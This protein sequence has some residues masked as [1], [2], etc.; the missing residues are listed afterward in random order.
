MDNADMEN[1]DM[2]NAD[3]ENADMENANMENADIENRDIEN[4]DKNIK[5]SCMVDGL[6]ISCFFQILDKIALKLIHT[7]TIWSTPYSWF[8]PTLQ[9]NVP[10]FVAKFGN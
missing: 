1:A 6:K 5:N 9:C 4:V 10:N 7:V 8:L 3:M 2:E